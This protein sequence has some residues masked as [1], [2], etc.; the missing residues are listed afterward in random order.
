MKNT[1][2]LIEQYFSG[3]IKLLKLAFGFWDFLLESFFVFDVRF[4]KF[5][6]F[7]Y[8]SEMREKKI[9]NLQHAIF[10]NMYIIL[11]IQKF[12]EFLKLDL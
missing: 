11:L 12:C 3:W 4:T 1:Y 10:K 9:Y 6:N 2:N 5:C 7:K 8:F